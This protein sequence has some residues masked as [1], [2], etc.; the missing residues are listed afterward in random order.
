[1]EVDGLWHQGPPLD[2]Q[3]GDMML[4]VLKLLANLNMQERRAAQDGMFGASFDSKIF[5]VSISSKGV[6][7]GERV[8]FKLAPPKDRFSK[9]PDI[10]MRKAC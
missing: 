4:A 2:R 5:N 8:L 10:G 1:M 7:T 3:S 9:L 6:K